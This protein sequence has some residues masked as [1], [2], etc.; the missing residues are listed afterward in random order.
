MSWEETVAKF[1]SLATPVYGEEKARKLCDLV[2]NLENSK[3]FALDLAK[4]LD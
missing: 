3:D 2:D 4:C 1:M